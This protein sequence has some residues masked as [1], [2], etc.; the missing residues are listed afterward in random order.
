MLT[1][2]YLLHRRDAPDQPLGQGVRHAD[3]DGAAGPQNA[4]DLGQQERVVGDVLEDLGADNAVEGSVGE[5]QVQRVGL[6]DAGAGAQ[7]PFH[8][9]TEPQELERLQLPQVAV[10]ADGDAS[11]P[12]GVDDVPARAA[13]D[14]EEAVAVAQAEEVE[15]DRVQSRRCAV[16]IGRLVPVRGQSRTARRSLGEFAQAAVRTGRQARVAF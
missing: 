15:I 2:R 7:L 3:S 5:G 9:Q 6:G 1:R 11:P 13:A 8:A 16:A 12:A 10:E 4:G 14:V